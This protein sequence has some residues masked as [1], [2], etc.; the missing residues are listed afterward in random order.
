METKLTME[1][2]CRSLVAF[3]GNKAHYGGGLSFFSSV[4]NDWNSIE[5][6]ECSYRNNIARIGSAVDFTLQQWIDCRPQS[7]KTVIPMAYVSSC[8]FTSNIAN[9]DSTG[10]IGVGAV[11]LNGVNVFIKYKALFMTNTG[12]GLSMT[13]S[14]FKVTDNTLVTF[15]RNKGKNG[16]AIAIFDKAL[17]V[18]GKHSTINFTENIAEYLGGAIYHTSLG[19]Y[20]YIYSRYCFLQY[21]K[22]ESDNYP[23][24]TFTNNKANEK[25]NSIYASTVL[26]C[27]RDI[28]F[29]NHNSDMFC[30]DNTFVYNQ[31]NESCHKQ[32]ATA[33]SEIV[34]DANITSVIPGKYPF[35]INYTV[36]SS[37]NNYSISKESPLI[38]TIINDDENQSNVS[39]RF[40]NNT[41]SRFSYISNHNL[42][43]TG[44]E[45]TIV[46]VTLETEYPITFQRY[47]SIKFQKCPPGFKFNNETFI[48]DCAGDY[49]KQLICDQSNFQASILRT[50]WI[51][52]KL[53][54][55]PDDEL[56]VAFSPY[57]MRTT[58]DESILLPQTFDMNKLN[59]HLCGALNRK[60]PLCG[61]C[62]AGYGVSVNTNDYKCV[63]CSVQS[64]N[65][66]WLYYIAT[67][68]VPV[69]IFFIL[70]FLFSKRITHGPLNS[71]VFFSQIITSTVQMNAYGLTPIRKTVKSFDV[72]QDIYTIP[73]DFWNLK[74][75]PST[76]HGFCLSPHLG[77]LSVLALGY[78]T[79]LY[80][81]LMVL[82]V[83]LLINF[84]NK[85]VKAVVMLIRPFHYCLARFR[86]LTKLKFSITAGIAVFILMSYNKFATVS[87][88]LIPFYHLYDAKGRINEAVFY[89]QGSILFP[90]D[91][92][93]YFIS[94]IIVLSTFGTIPP[95]IL[96]YPSLLKLIER[97]RCVRSCIQI[98]KYYPNSKLQAFLDEFHGC[99]KNG[100]QTGE[101]DCRWFAS[102]YFSL[103]IF[104]LLV[105]SQTNTWQ[106][107]YLYQ[108]MIFLSC[109]MLF[110]II[111]PY[112]EDWINNVDTC[113]FAILTAVSTLSLYNLQLATIQENI[114]V[115]AFAIQFILMMIPMSYCLVY[116]FVLFCKWSKEKC[117][118]YVN[119]RGTTDVEENCHDEEPLSLDNSSTYVERFFEF[120]QN[121][122]RFRDK[123]SLR[124][125]SSSLE[126]YSYGTVSSEQ[127]Y[128]Q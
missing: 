32:I 120:I 105:F 29:A 94:A 14:L 41:K 119:T 128:R 92:I 66:N 96:V 90:Q 55:A 99:Y 124:L 93:L 12:S 31:K 115:V 47:I 77:T 110:S 127:D 108:S 71:F 86:Q 85:G 46:N 106:Q 112:R 49:N 4:W 125:S 27:L 103:R 59:N 50:S 82:I 56:F 3:N 36:K 43:L 58:F 35:Y 57:V 70:V 67:E 6:R 9:N 80:P 45:D 101:M 68:F 33:P 95:I 28:S 44:K 100:N 74:F 72:F 69:T 8:N 91:G 38:A 42:Y 10:L 109:T 11:N 122:G 60:G 73:Y 39:L 37:T 61:D 98:E 102:F 84:Y 97:F 1:V 53:N 118:E 48:C 30:K 54:A 62:K 34:T 51:G 52:Q 23:K 16:G 113:I 116:Y 17:I 64:Q 81:L 18:V 114:S 104:L 87:F 22:T 13:H 5:F 65:Y 89:H 117:Q 21:D 121:S 83:V 2:D 126:D 15:Y 76:F 7:K 88:N 19:I 123:E 20:D 78:V 25:P 79:A 40:P 26:P 107:L 111:R 75:F 24:F 63:K